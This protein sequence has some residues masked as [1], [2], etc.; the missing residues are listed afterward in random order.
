M[1]YIELDYYLE[2]PQ[3]VLLINY[4]AKRK[5]KIKQILLQAKEAIR[6]MI[7]CNVGAPKEKR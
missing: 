2:E 1:D 6:T 3:R 5:N 7:E 4:L